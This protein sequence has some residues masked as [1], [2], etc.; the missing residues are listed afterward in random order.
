MNG[1]K[2]KIRKHRTICSRSVKEDNLEILRKNSNIKFQ[3]IID[4]GSHLM[5]D[6]QITFIKF[7]LLEPNG[8][9]RIFYI[10]TRRV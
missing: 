2:K 10:R 4:D 7:E 6:Q 1:Q 5:Y 8:Y 3:V 9:Y